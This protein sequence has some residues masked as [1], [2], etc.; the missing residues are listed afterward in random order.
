M[1][2]LTAGIL[3]TGGM[4]DAIPQSPARAIHGAPSRRVEVQCWA[5]LGVSRIMLGVHIRDYGA[6]M[7]MITL[8]S[9]R[10]YDTPMRPQGWVAETRKAPSIRGLS[11][12][13]YRS[14]GDEPAVA[15]D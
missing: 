10:Y 3:G 15:L 6:S 13:M 2:T 12:S 8:Y 11:L 14:L 5:M 9:L 1:A 7:S 4:A